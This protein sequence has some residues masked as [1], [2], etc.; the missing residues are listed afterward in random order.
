[1]WLVI[2]LIA[3]NGVFDAAGMRLRRLPD[4]PVAYERQTTGDW[5]I[6]SSRVRPKYVHEPVEGGGQCEL[7]ID[8]GRCA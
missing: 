5:G 1:V 6:A 3:L 7:L 8:R 4:N 2:A